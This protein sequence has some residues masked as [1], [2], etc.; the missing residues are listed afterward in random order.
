VPE[1]TEQ[2]MKPRSPSPSQERR[3]KHREDN[4]AKYCQALGIDASFLD[5]RGL[6]FDEILTDLGWSGRLNDDKKIEDL[7][8]D[9]RREIGRVQATSWLGNIEQQEGKIDQLAKL[10]DKTIEECEELDGLLTLYSHELSVSTRIK[11]Q[12]DPC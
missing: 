4:T 3:R 10:I 8:A 2:K 6:D 5:G 12:N 7:E 9:I 11:I 1:I